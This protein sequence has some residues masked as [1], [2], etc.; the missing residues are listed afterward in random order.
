MLTQTS[1]SNTEQVPQEVSSKDKDHVTSI[2]RTSTTAQNTISAMEE[3]TMT[4][5]VNNNKLEEMNKNV[6]VYT[7]RF[8]DENIWANISRSTERL[9]TE[10]AKMPPL[11]KLTTTSTNTT[12]AKKPKCHCQLY[13]TKEKC[14][15]KANASSTPNRFSDIIRHG[16][17]KNKT[18]Y[19]NNTNN[20]TT[21][22]Q[23]LR[24][25]TDFHTYE[26]CEHKSNDTLDFKHLSSNSMPNDSARKQRVD[27]HHNNNTQTVEITNVS[28]SDNTCNRST[29]PM[30]G[31]CE[32]SQSK[33]KYR[34]TPR[35]DCPSRRRCYSHERLA[36]PVKTEPLTWLQQHLVLKQTIKTCHKCSSLTQTCHQR[37]DSPQ[38]AAYQGTHCCQAQHIIRACCNN[39]ECLAQDTEEKK[40]PT[41]KPAEHDKSTNTEA[42]QEEAQQV[43][44]DVKL[45]KPITVDIN[46]RF[47][48]KKKDADK[49]QEQKEETA[50]VHSS[51][52][53]ASTAVQGDENQADILEL[54]NQEIR[55]EF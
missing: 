42:Y 30:H 7:S 24:A 26:R 1:H 43:T 37:F 47:V 38:T 2:V 8:D 14:K 19:F 53:I 18:S 31:F 51:S 21:I 9:D 13:K 39:K 17:T 10:W 15:C 40:P 49:K 12:T 3:D 20:T 11:P 23:P 34:K 29:V 41:P 22:P 27:N 16:N 28:A 48:P 54:D 45:K 4:E 33:T 44:K 32:R 50:L 46:V 5:M 36:S 35:W 25:T 55:T 52:L 6:N